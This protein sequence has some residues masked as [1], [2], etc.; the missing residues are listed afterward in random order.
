MRTVLA[1]F[2]LVALCDAGAVGFFA[3][4]GR[5]EKALGFAVL[6]VA[7]VVCMAALALVLRRDSRRGRP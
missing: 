1:L 5:P 2:T 4:A 6:F 3:F 7:A